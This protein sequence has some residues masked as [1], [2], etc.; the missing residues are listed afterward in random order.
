[1][2]KRVIDALLAKNW[3]YGVIALRAKID[4]NRLRSANLGRREMD[5]L[6]RVAECEAGIDVDEL[7]GEE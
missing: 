5:R 6:M 3:T 4:E 2:P 1:M 7:E